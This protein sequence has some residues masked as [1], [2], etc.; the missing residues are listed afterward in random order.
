MT[1]SSGPGG[2]LPLVPFTFLALPPEVHT[3]EK[4]SVVILPVPYDATASFRPGARE[5]PDAIIA[6]SR[7][8]EDYDIELGCEPSSGGIHTVP[9]L[10]PDLG[11][12]QGMVDG[13]LRL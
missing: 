4:S 8:L 9:A 1:F 13:W 7:E 5:G 2:D 6:A 12:P 3:Y 11:S 10:E